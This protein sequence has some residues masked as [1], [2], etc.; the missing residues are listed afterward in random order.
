MDELPSYNRIAPNV[1]LG[2][3][4]KIFGFANLYGCE[5]E[6]SFVAKLRDETKFPSLDALKGQI[7]AD[8]EHAKRMFDEGS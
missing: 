5:I 1:K 2:R 4:V 7:A 6:L 8:I 3:D